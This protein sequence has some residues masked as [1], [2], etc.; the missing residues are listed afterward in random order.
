MYLMQLKSLSEKNTNL[1]LTLREPPRQL[2]R[3][4]ALKNKGA[5]T[6]LRLSAFA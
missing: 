2:L 6:T 4:S 3:P 1:S 5:K